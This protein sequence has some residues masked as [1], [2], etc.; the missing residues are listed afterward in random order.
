MSHRT[1]KILMF[2]L[3]LV[4]KVFAHNEGLRF[5]ENKG[6]WKEPFLFKSD[7]GNGAVFLEPNSFTY[8][9]YNADEIQSNHF[10]NKPSEIPIKYHAFRVNFLNAEKAVIQSQKKY[11]EYFNYLIGKNKT[12]WK[13]KVNAYGQ[14]EYKNLYSG[15]DLIV[16]SLGNL[17]K[18]DLVI[19]PKTDISKV[20]LQYE[21]IDKIKIDRSGNLVVSTSVGDLIEQK[22][23]AYQTIDGKKIEISCN[24]VLKGNTL[25]YQITGKYN[26][27][28]PIIIDPVLIFSSFSGSYANNFGMT[29]TYGYDGSLF[30]GGTAFG[31]GFPTSLGA[32][33]SSFNG[34]P[35][36][37][38]TDIVITR[39]DSSGTSLIYSTYI[40][41]VQTDVAHSLIANKNN[42][43]YLYGTSSSLDY[44]ILGNSY[45]TSFNGGQAVN[46]VNTGTNFVNG[47]DIIISKLSNDGT[48]LM[49]ST[50][51][52]GSNNDGINTTVSRNYDSLMYNYGDIFRGDIALDSLE[53]C[54]ITSSSR[55]S[56][57]P[58]VNGFDTGLNGL[59]DGIVF[60]MDKNLS[61]LHWSSYIGGSDVD[62]GYSIKV[63]DSNYVYVCGGTSSIDFTTTPGTINSGYQGG[64]AD[65]YIVKIDSMGT[66]LIN[67]TI[68]GTTTY[69]QCYFL[70]VDRFGYIY[71]VGQTRGSFPVINAPY[72][73]PNSSSFI[74]KLN[75]NLSA[76]SY[77]TIFGNGNINAKFSPSAFMVDRCENIYVSGWGGDILTGINLNGMPTTSNAVFPSSP[78]GFDFYLIVLE[79]NV[80]SLLYGTYFGGSLSRE[81]V[82]GGTS[83]FDKNGIVYQS[84]C[85]GCQNNDDFPSSPGAWSATNNSSGCNN[86]VFKFDFE[87]IPKA[88]FTVDQHEGCAPL[89]VTFTNNS[90][91]SD[92]YFWDFGGGD[93]TSQVFN[94]IRTYTVPGTYSATLIIQ[95][96]ICNTID[97]AYQ[98]I[99]VNPPILIQS[100]SN[101]T[102]SCNP[103]LLTV[104]ASGATDFI[105]SSNNQFSDTLNIGLTDT[106][107]VFNSQPTT[108]Y[109]MATNGICNDTDSVTIQF[110]VPSLPQIY[111]NQ[112]QGCVPLTVQFANNTTQYDYFLWNFGNGDTTSQ[113]VNPIITYNSAGIFPVTLT[114]VDSI[115]Q[116]SFTDSVTIITD[117]IVTISPPSVINTCD[118]ALLFTN[119]SNSI[120]YVWS[121]SPLFTDTLNSNFEDSLIVQVTDTTRFYVMA[122]NGVCTTTDSVLVNYIGVQISTQ[123]GAICSGQND[124]LQVNNH[125][126]LPLSYS[127][128]PTSLI[129]SGENTANPIVNPTTSTIYYVNAQNS[130]GCSAN[131][132]VLVVVS[133]FNANNIN[134]SADKDT[135]INGEGTYLHAYPDTN[136]SYSWIPPI[137]LSSNSSAN[138][139]ATPTTTTTYTVNFTENSS[140]CMYQKSYTLYVFEL[141]CGEPDVFLP[142]AFTPNNDN[143]NDILYL[144]GRNVEKMHLKI[145]NRWGELVFETENQTIGWDGKYNGKLVDPAVFV[146]HLSVKCIDGQDYFKKGNVTV[147]R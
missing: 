11:P 72:N 141:V 27:H 31:V 70:E 71:V 136:F 38:I 77:S 20:Q 24:Y 147:I 113:I 66:Q 56:D 68:L 42:E 46:Y 133:G 18:Y 1:F 112:S 109:V 132:S 49:A 32:F 84:V 14:I 123:S 129:I 15:V 145:Y 30:S 74:V 57:F 117:S 55:S 67:S 96:S 124:T 19:S 111:T 65:G 103:V 137:N 127:W 63:D 33:D 34:V 93:T 73:N 116:T 69:D 85:A 121:S 102:T 53:N 80:Q 54:Y 62:A 87:I 2:I 35:G 52:G 9:F 110:H 81:H 50:Y 130:F 86:G 39:Y 142:N 5:I 120:G 90:N 106:I 82:D 118:S 128:T 105:W 79:R 29:A 7:L 115:C 94:P 8:C 126:N 44:P 98:T 135:L 104:S 64:I 140:G 36:S 59:Q 95:D 4:S 107:T 47:T 100:V 48:T 3:V 6:Q 83:R 122:I 146:Y 17:M 12:N 97:T 139:F 41:G 28:L 75:N 21:G 119:G 138:P 114:V 91:S 88:E 144:R 61:T 40:G 22:P 134:V 89:T 16:Y 76:I 125:T 13:G 37:G 45:D 143:E 101:D 60:K 108:Y 131:D 26:I 51:I 10:S 25:S 23:Y 99:I 58:I 43:L 78:N 92:S